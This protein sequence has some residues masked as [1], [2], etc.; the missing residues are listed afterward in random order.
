MAADEQA[1]IRRAQR[2]DGKAFEQIV[3]AYE[4][5]LFNLALRMVKDREDA[6]DLTQSVLIKAYEGLGSFDP[7][8]RFFSWV[9]R[10]MINESLNLL[11]RRRPVEALDERLPSDA[12]TPD[13]CAER[14]RVAE[15]VQEA[16]MEVSPE[17]REVVVLRHFLNLS[18]EEMSDVLQIPE[19][20]VKSR[21]YAARQKLGAVLKRRGVV[22]A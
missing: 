6:R 1:L 19:K 16:L 4:G 3:A 18:H 11:K 13:E 12:A 9:Y 20:T 8:R 7:R 22:S 2:G 14:A 5:L 10:I 17:H 21:L 15:I